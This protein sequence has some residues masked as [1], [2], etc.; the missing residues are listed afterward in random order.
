VSAGALAML[1]PPS[2]PFI[3]YGAVSGVS[4]ADLFIG[5]IIPG[6]VL[7]ASLSIYI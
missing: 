1:I 4:V 2:V 7:A 5:G 6:I 3:I